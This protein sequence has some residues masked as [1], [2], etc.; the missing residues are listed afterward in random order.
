[1]NKMNHSNEATPDLVS[2]VQCPACKTQ[3]AWVEKNI[4]RPFCSESCK[5]KD[6]IGW[7]NEDKQ[8]SGSA[9]YDDVFSENM[10]NTD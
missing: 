3:V 4:F 7:A 2:K 6:F 1:M 5:N 10:A 9:D 8:I